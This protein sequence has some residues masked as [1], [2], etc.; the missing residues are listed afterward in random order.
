[1]FRPQRA[2]LRWNNIN[3]LSMVLSMP[4]YI[5]WIYENYAWKS[6][7][8]VVW[9]SSECRSIPPCSQ[10]FNRLKN[11]VTRDKQ[12]VILL[13]LQLLLLTPFLKL[14]SVAWVRERTILTE[15]PPL[16][17]EVSANYLG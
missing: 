3:H 4:Q 14:N 10:L 7:F 15:R 8:I 9:A 5:K 13:F 12:S 16:V 17:G 6:L 1:M 2:I 11:C